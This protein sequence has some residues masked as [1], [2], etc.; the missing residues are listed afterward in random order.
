MR[1]SPLAA[2]RRHGTRSCS[3]AGA[4]LVGATGWRRRV[5]IRVRRFGHRFRAGRQNLLQA[6]DVDDN[7][8]LLWVDGD[9]LDNRTNEASLLA[10]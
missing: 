2:I 7:V 3:G 1:F 5:A 6:A 9:L 8:E 10:Q 4:A